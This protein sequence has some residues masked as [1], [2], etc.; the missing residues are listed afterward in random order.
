MSAS[1][2][3]LG[4]GVGLDGTVAVAV[5]VGVGEA[6][7]VAVAVAVPVA[8]GVGPLQLVVKML[9]SH[10]PA[11]VPESPGPPSNTYNDHVPLASVPLKADN[12]VAY[13]G[14]GAGDGYVVAGG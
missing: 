1:P 2:L 14:V 9:S 5:A 4:V 8:V 7:A 12:T 6:V 3:S 10:P 13:G 11:M